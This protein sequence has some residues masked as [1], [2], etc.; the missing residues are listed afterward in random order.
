MRVLW[1]VLWIISLSAQSKELLRLSSSQYPAQ[2]LMVNGNVSSQ[3]VD[4][5]ACVLEKMDQQYRITTLP[6]GRAIKDLKQDASDGIFTAAPSAELNAIATM[7]APFALE[8]WHWY[9][10]PQHKQTSFSL[11]NKVIGVVRSSNVDAWL[12]QRGLTATIEVNS[13]EQLI[14]MLLKGRIDVFL[15][16][17]FKVVNQLERLHIPLDAMEANFSHYMP[18]GVYF[19]KRLLQRTPNFMAQ[20]NQA[21]HSC[22]TTSM[23]LSAVE[24]EKI[25]TLVRKTIHSQVNQLM[26]LQTALEQHN[27]ER[28]GQ[29]K[30]AGQWDQ[31]WLL[32]T[33]QDSGPLLNQVRQHPLSPQLAALQTQSQGLISEIYVTGIQGFNVAMSQTTSDFDQSDEA[34]YAA[35]ILRK[36]PLYIGDI[37]FDPSTQHFQSKVA[38]PIMDNHRVLGMIVFGL[39]VEFALRSMEQNFAP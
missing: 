22:A 24:K 5:L 4:I 18:L 34:E 6:W 11:H 8:K 29:E 3:S 21:L 33:Q 1:V 9:F 27:Q 15:E 35:I 38:W 2:Q 25:T 32:E 19:S 12:K 26:G 37:E 7:S 23:Q 39:D 13:V 28:A 10:L 17:E 14:R 36:R 16:D 31:Q 30:Q 20:F